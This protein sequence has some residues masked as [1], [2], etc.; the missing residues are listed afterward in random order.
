MNK[1]GINKQKF[2]FLEALFVA[3]LIFGIGFFLGTWLES[4]RASKIDALYSL[5]EINLF[6]LNSHNQFVGLIDCENSADELI[7]FTDRVYEEA[8]LLS[9]YDSASRLTQDIVIKHRKYDLLRATLF[10]SATKTKQKCNS[11][12]DIVAYFYD[13]QDVSIDTKSKQIAF[14]KALTELKN[15]KGGDIILIPMAGDN[16]LISVDLVMKRYKITELPSILINEN[17]V[18]TE[19]EDLKDIESFL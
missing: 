12:Y 3:I 10:L 7:E 4:Y 16:D 6:D 1:K 14:S 13:Y 2:T 8:K 11:T 9:K 17:K 5:S 15:K 19:I 18:I